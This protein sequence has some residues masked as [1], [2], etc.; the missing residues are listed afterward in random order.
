MALSFHSVQRSPTRDS[1]RPL[2]SCCC[3]RAL[4]LMPFHF[5]M[6]HLTSAFVK[7]A[8][9]FL[10]RVP[11]ETFLG[12][13]LTCCWC[14]TAVLAGRSSLPT[15]PEAPKARASSPAI[16]AFP[17]KER[18]LSPWMM[19]FFVPERAPAARSTPESHSCA[20]PHSAEQY[21]L[22]LLSS[23][24]SSRV[25]LF[26][27]FLTSFVSL[28]SSILDARYCSANAVIPSR[29]PP[30]ILMKVIIMLPELGRSID[31]VPLPPAVICSSSLMLP[32]TEASASSRISTASSSLPSKTIPTALS[33]ARST[34]LPAP[35]SSSS[36]LFRSSR[37]RTT[38]LG[39]LSRKPDK[40]PARA[41]L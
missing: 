17:R 31:P 35:T 32:P 4:L 38:S 10:A 5:L 34:A 3:P 13:S 1:L 18:S 30:C 7:E 22:T 2:M 15:S 39:S 24:Y 25:F 19:V 29:P 21:L 11:V 36:T 9:G 37:P 12:A 20:K 16:Q 8:S 27:I 14:R 23:K 33:P 28:K 41:A 40:I 6:S 26:P